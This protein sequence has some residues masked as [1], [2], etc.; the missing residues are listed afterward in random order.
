[1]SKNEL[2]KLFIAFGKLL[3]KMSEEEYDAF[4]NN[5]F[6]GSK[7]VTDKKKKTAEKKEINEVEIDNFIK[8]LQ[9]IDSR[10]EAR[11]FI[12]DNELFKLKDNLTKIAKKLKV[13]IIKNDKKEDIENKII[14]FI[15]G[16][17][18]RTD[19]FRGLNLGNSDKEK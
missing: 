12:N 15:I 5:N 14:E 2:S 1:M 13:H 9:S 11:K 6:D 7:I 17:K 4:L 8:Q 3:D 16:S 18:L 19:A 10:D